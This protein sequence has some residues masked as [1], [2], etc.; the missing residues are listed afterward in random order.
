MTENPSDHKENSELIEELKP[1]IKAELEFC[2]EIDTPTVCRLTAQPGGYEK[3]EDMLIKRI[4]IGGLS[5][6]DA[7][8]SVENEFNIN[9]QE[10]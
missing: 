8:L 7:I 10:Y 1:L 2:N 5:V 6:A 4:A 9:R 3:V